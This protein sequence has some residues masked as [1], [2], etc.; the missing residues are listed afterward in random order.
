MKKVVLLPLLFSLT[1]AFSSVTLFSQTGM[2]AILE[3]CTGTWC[4]ACPCGDQA[5][6]N[7]QTQNPDLLVL[8]YHGPANYGADPFTGFNGN[9]ILN[10]MGFTYYPSGVIGRVSGIVGF[11]H[12]ENW[13]NLTSNYQPGVSYSITKNYNSSTRQLNV[14]VTATALR[15]IDTACYINFVIYEGNIVY[16]QQGGSC[17]GGPNYVHFWVLR[18]MVNGATGEVLHTTGW[19]QGTTA[20]K[21]WNTSIDE[22]VWTANNCTVAIFCYLGN[23]SSINTSGSPVIQTWKESIIP[24]GVG[25]PSKIPA[26]YSL[27]QNYPNPFNPSTNIKFS[28]PKDGNASLKIYDIVGNEVAT[29]L[30]GFVKAGEYN[31]LID[32]S[33]WASGVYFYKLTTS[34]FTETKKMTL[35]K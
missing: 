32:A 14:N 22:N 24:T 23:G 7:L 2:N 11:N 21:S 35:I 29:Y 12:W 10:L 17:P 20:T 1:A 6:Y 19:T 4:N 25:E 8:A 5:A 28:I 30:E 27:S 18:N 13:V 26:S 16:P 3:F 9:D 33:N 15:N 34:D 31:A